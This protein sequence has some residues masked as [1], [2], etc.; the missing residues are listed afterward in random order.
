MTQRDLQVI[1]DDEEGVIR[2]M[3]S[4]GT[5][6]RVARAME[7]VANAEDAAASVQVDDVLAE[8]G[9]S[10]L[11]IVKVYADESRLSYATP[12]KPA[13]LRKRWGDL[14]GIGLIVLFWFFAVIG[15]FWLVRELMR[16]T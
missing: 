11:E 9:M 2:L 1:W 5:L 10:S 6:R 13:A 16:L 3:G 7:G 8:E 15:F 14:V 12:V 4:A